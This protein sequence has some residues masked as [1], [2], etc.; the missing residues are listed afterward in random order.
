MLV[1]DGE[2]VRLPRPLA[3]GLWHR[4]YGTV[5]GQ[6]RHIFACFAEPMLLAL[7]GDAACRS[8]GR[9]VPVERLDAL[10]DL[11][12]RHGFFVDRLHANGRPVAPARLARFSA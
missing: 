6:G 8:V 4:V 1:L 11:A 12:A 7:A 10:A 3:G 5:T 2:Y 9:D